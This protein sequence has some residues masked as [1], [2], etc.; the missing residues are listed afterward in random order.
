MTQSKSFINWGFEAAATHASESFLNQ[1]YPYQRK[2]SF[3]TD[4]SFYFFSVCWTICQWTLLCLTDRTLIVATSDNF[5]QFTTEHV[6]WK[7]FKLSEVQM[8]L[9]AENTFKFQ[10][11]FWKMQIMNR[12]IVAGALKWLEVEATDRWKLNFRTI[13]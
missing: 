5:S 2:F 4:K 12:Y 9:K 6:F 3:L 8:N 13:S 10:V 1:S 11:E 7:F